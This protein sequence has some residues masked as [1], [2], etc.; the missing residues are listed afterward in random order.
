MITRKGWHF[1]KK[2]QN[3][4]SIIVVFVLKLKIRMNDFSVDNEIL[5]WVECLMN[6]FIQKSFDFQ[7]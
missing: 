6:R 4:F 1:R 5:W 2:R 3:G 7:M